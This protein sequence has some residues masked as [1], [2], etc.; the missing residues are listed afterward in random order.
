MNSDDIQVQ[1][2]AIFS[3]E[4]EEHLQAMNQH[5][6]TLEDGSAIGARE[7]LMAGSANARRVYK[8]EG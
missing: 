5:L 4:A 6:L 2:M 1:L 7:Q 3:V 8:V